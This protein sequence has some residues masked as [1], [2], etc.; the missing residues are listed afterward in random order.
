MTVDKRVTEL[1]FGTTTTY[2]KDSVGDAAL[3]NSRYTH[4]TPRFITGWLLMVPLL[5]VIK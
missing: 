1:K 4:Y 5:V 3:Q 2:I